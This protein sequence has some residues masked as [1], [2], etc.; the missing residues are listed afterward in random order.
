MSNPVFD[1]TIVEIILEMR[2]RAHVLNA[3]MNPR[4]SRE[5][6]I[7]NAAADALEA[8]NR[9]PLSEFDRLMK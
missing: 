9:P 2:R 8:L 6:T 5:A 4:P 7:L 1:A 3:W